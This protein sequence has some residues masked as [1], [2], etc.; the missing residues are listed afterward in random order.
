M[1]KCFLIILLIFGIKGRLVYGGKLENKIDSVL[2][3]IEFT[4]G[5]KCDLHQWS[6]K[7]YGMMDKVD[8]P[9]SQTI[10]K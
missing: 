8:T 6:I 10:L 5:L 1:K 2:Q 7:N 3:N 4:M 9:S